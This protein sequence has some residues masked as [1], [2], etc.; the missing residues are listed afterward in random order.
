M[1]QVSVAA[2]YMLTKKAYDH[3]VDKPTNDDDGGLSALSCHEWLCAVQSQADYR[4]KSMELDLLFL[5]FVKPCRTA[6]FSLYMETLGHLIPWVFV[7]DHTHFAQNLPI[8]LCD[9][10]TLEEILWMW[11][12][13]VVN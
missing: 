9:M 2:L 10:A 3:Y 11:I 12:S 7:L 6:D 13:N 5:E 1:H 8:H 4:F